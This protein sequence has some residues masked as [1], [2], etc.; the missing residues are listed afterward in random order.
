MEDTTPAMALSFE[1]GD[2]AGVMK[3]KPRKVSE[4]I[5][6]FSMKKLIGVYAVIM[7]LSLLGMFVY[8]W[9]KTADL[10]YSRT[11]VFVGLGIVSIFYIYAVRN[12]KKPIMAVNPLSNKFLF[13]STIFGLGL[14]LAALYI[15][16]FQKIL[17]TVPLGAG[18]WMLLGGYCFMSLFL[19][20]AGKWFFVF[21]NKNN[22]LRN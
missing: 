16:F 22:Y 7:D 13:F 14:I 3:E 20:E 17:K 19:V 9:R 2:S 21:R 12:L 6:D 5:L 4:P 1:A 18:D 15:P 11:I 8:F 10:D